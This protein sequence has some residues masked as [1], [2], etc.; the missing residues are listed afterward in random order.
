MTSKLSRFLHLE[1]PR[2]ERP[3]AEATSRLQSSGRFEAPVE[4]GEAPQEAAIPET[5]LERFRGHEPLVLAQAPDASLRFPRCMRCE[6]E[7]GRFVTTCVVCGADL[8][9]PQQREYDERRWQEHGPG[10]LQARDTV[11]EKLRLDEAERMADAERYA[12]QLEQLR[13]AERPHRWIRAFS[14]HSTVGTALLSLI[15]D[16]RVRWLTLATVVAVPV[17]MCRYGEG[18]VPFAGVLL[19]IVLLALFMPAKSRRR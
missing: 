19:G 13:E 7:N 2:A 14:Q 9:T 17:G 12:R 15:P 10:L 4:R 5:H 1:R 8:E 3:E 18:R 6:S 16:A 11:D